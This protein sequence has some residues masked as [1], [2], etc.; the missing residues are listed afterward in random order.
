M[1]IKSNMGNFGAHVHNGGIY[2]KITAE[3]PHDSEHFNYEFEI[4]VSNFACLTNTTF[5]LQDRE[6]VEEMIAA[7]TNTLNHMKSHNI[8]EYI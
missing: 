1:E 7:L 4:G 6:L 2:G 3:K 5:N 8:A